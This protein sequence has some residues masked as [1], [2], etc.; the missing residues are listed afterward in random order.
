MLLGQQWTPSVWPTRSRHFCWRTTLPNWSAVKHSKSEP[1]TVTCFMDLWEINTNRAKVRTFK[2]FW[3]LSFRRFV[4]VL[5]RMEDKHVIVAGET[6]TGKSVYLSP[7]SRRMMPQPSAAQHLRAM[8]TCCRLWLQKD[9]PE[10][11]I[12]LFIN[13]SVQSSVQYIMHTIYI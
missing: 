10:S 13:F 4:S 8:K 2:V 9:A 3:F 1:L 12:P 11:I 5:W 7:G 6:G